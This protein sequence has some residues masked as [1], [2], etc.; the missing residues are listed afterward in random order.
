MNIQKKAMVLAAALLLSGS[1]VAQ[2]NTQLKR[3]NK[4]YELFAYNLAIP[5]YEEALKRRAD[6]VE[7][8][9]KIADSHRHLN[10]LDQAASYYARAVR[11]SNVEKIHIL[12]YGHVL[13]GLGRYEEAK[14][15]YLLYARDEDGQVGNHY[16]QSCDFA[17]T[18]MTT[19]S[20]FTVTNEFINTSASDFGASFR[21]TSQVV[22]SS[23]RTDIQRSSSNWAGKANNQLF[24]ANMGPNGYLES[25]AFL[26]NVAKAAYN[27]GPISFSPDGRMVAFTR[28]NF[29]DGT[30]QIP[31]A[32]AE[33]SLLL[34]EIN[35]NGDWINVRPFPFNGSD[36]STGY[37]AFSPDGTS[38]YFAS[39]RPGGF[40]GYDI[41]VARWVGNDW[42][43]LENLGPT[44]NSQ[45]HEI[46]PYVDGQSLYFASDWHFG[47]GGFDNFRAEKEGERWARIFH[48]GNAANTPADDYAFIFDS[49][50]NIGYVTSNR[51]GGRGAEDIYRVSRQADVVVIRI[52]N[53]ADGSPISGAEVDFVNCGE[54]VYQA[55]DRGV[56][57]FQAVQG[58]NCNVVVR[59][60]GYQ[61]SVV[62]VATGGSMESKAYEV[63]LSKVGESYAGR[64]V[65]YNS[66]LPLDNVFVTAINQQS[67]ITSTVQT[68]VNGEYY[69]PLATYSNY[70]LR[71]SRQGYRDLSI[72][73]RTQDGFDRTILGVISMLPATSDLPDP[74]GPTPVNPGTE[75]AP[76][77]QMQRGFA[78]QVA[79]VSNADLEPFRKLASVGTVYAKQDGSRYRVRVGVFNTRQ[80]A[81]KA[82]RTV[83]R[84]HADAFIVAEE[85]ADLSARGGVAPTLP[86]PAA[87][88]GTYKV[89]LGAFSK[90]E[91]FDSRGLENFGNIEDEPRGRFTVKSLTGFNVLS[92][93]QLALQRARDAGFKDAFILVSDR[94]NWVRAR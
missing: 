59:K 19:S 57:S 77:A 6:D 35:A 78:V 69:L 58:L 51:L 60:E 48:L 62:Q 16:A 81:E 54:G 64:V 49:A 24:V 85:G 87:S 27:E 47:L 92:E 32:G 50:R 44:V 93:A 45:G 73:T 5:S 9:S 1:L 12:N 71:Y 63:V 56:Y 2:F 52:K 65:G 10:Q 7:A 30:R 23:A 25:P 43:T 21:G 76:Q 38:L 88:S 42:G 46:T 68:N 11:Q 74:V 53:A 94:G 66:R 28:N 86:P 55:D 75:T 22:F 29:T 14:Q 3:A 4:Q 8:L 89:Q 84:T 26:R 36:F 18:Q 33:L 20:P 34:A 79:A 82:L 70:A 39:D 40:G 41:Y 15:F 31:S 91:L 37:P 72:T 90:P 80:D 67:G 13:K 83:R 61:N 17:R